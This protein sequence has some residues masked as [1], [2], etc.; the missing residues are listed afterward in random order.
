MVA[1]LARIADRRATRSTRI[2][3]TLPSA[4]FFDPGRLAREHRAGST[5]GVGDVVLAALAAQ[6]AVGQ[7]DLDHRDPARP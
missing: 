6:L 7:V 2:I 5:L 1:I 3:S 4:D